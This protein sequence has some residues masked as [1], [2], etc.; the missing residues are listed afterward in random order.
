M[1]EM[2]LRDRIGA[3]FNAAYVRSRGARLR[4]RA[5]LTKKHT[6]PAK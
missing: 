4:W 6:N 2:L 5:E 3:T 1:L